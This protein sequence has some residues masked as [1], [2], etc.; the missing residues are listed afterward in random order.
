MH[1]LSIALSD[2]ALCLLSSYLALVRSGTDPKDF[3]RGL[4]FSYTKHLTLTLQKDSDLDADP[5]TK[6]KQWWELEDP[7]F[8]WNKYLSGPLAG[9]IS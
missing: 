5:A 2:T 6:D 8:F 7:R 9:K 4:Y 1:I 3:G